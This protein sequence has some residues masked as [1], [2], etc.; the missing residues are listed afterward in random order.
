MDE[1]R[2]VLEGLH[3]VRADRVFEK[4]AHRAFCLE[5]GSTYD[6]AV[7]IVSDRDIGQALLKVFHVG[8]QA[9]D[10]HDLGGCGDGEYFV[11]RNAVDAAAYTEVQ[12]S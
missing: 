3:E 1:C 10:R 5:G 11:S 9:Q 6:V 12:A 2:C 8:S 7:H 4:N